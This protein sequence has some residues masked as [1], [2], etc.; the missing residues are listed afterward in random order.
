M[1]FDVLRAF[2]YPVLR[3]GSDDYVD[4]E[5][6]ATVD[7][8]ES[9]D[10]SQLTA[11]VEFALS[12]PEIEALVADGKAKFAAVFACRD[13]YFRRS[14][15]SDSKAFSEV[16]PAGNL[17]GDLLVYPYVV[18]TAEI[19]GFNCGW[20]NAEFGSGPFKFP[21]GSALAVDEPKMIYIDRDAF[22]PISSAFILVKKDSLPENEWQ[23]EASHD[24]VHIAVSPALKARIDLARNDKKKR[25]IL[26]NSLYFSAVMQ[27]LSLLKYGG[28][29]YDSYR[30]AKILR[31]RCADMSM[32]VKKHEESW[33]AQ[34]LMKHPVSVLDK[35]FF[36]DGADD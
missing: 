22:K 5:I 14:V 21:E 34:Q 13:T 17:R 18:A 8:Q 29:E 24:K 4:G 25:A 30:W 3:P 7:F 32:D 10:G 19:D 15:M 28:D 16:F 36:K 1:Q 31:Q 35:Y 20:I 27:C 2:P 26:L 11:S 33:M 12:V 23:I 9:D 6:Q